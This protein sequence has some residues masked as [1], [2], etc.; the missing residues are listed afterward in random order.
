MSIRTANLSGVATDTK[1]PTGAKCKA[2]NR[3]G[4]RCGGLAGSDGLC[5]DSSGAACVMM[6]ESIPCVAIFLGRLGATVQRARAVG[7]A[8]LRARLQGPRR[9]PRE[10]IW[11]VGR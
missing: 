11:A 7:A 9:S 2:K 4:E 1:R 3:G 8:A 5:S 10:L 6:L